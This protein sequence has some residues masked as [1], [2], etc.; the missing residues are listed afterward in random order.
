MNICVFCSAY[1][2]DPKYVKPA[3]ELARLIGTSHH[4]LVWGGSYVGLM[5]VMADGVRQSGGKLFGVSLE[6]YKN[7]LLKDADEMTIAKDLG[8][9][10]AAMLAKSD[11]SIVLPGGI[12]T[13]DEVTDLLELKK[14]NHHQKPIVLLNTDNFYEGLRIQLIKMEAENFLP[15]K[16]SDLVTFVDTPQ[17]ALRTAL[18]KS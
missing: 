13:L 5:K 9:R 18:R 11:A 15:L 1:V 17:E 4:N 3:A 2:D 14:Q 6:V 12:G 7:K 16:L 8:A 10:K